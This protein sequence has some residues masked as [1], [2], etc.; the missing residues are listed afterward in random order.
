MSF[1]FGSK[2]K[3]VEQSVGNVR[4][5]DYGTNEAARPLPLF[6]GMQ[7]IGG[8]FITDLFRKRAEP[9]T[10]SYQSGKN[11][12]ATTTTGYNYYS[13]YALALALG[14][15]DELKE[16]LA[17]DD[18]IWSG[19]LLRTGA[20]SNG[21]SSVTTEL[22]VIRIYWG[23]PT[24]NVD[25]LLATLVVDEG[26]G[27]VAAP[28]SAYRHFCYVV[29]DGLFF[30]QS[31]SPPNLQFVLVRKTSGLSISAHHINNDAVLPE[32]IYDLFTNKV[33]G[34]GVP[35]SR[36]D[37]ATFEAAAQT[38]I[39]EDL[40]MSPLI[41]S[42][43]KM[44]QV[45]ADM[46]PYVNGSVYR[47]GG[48]IMFALAR[49][50]MGPVTVY[51]P[52]DLVDEPEI[53]QKTWTDTFNES[54]VSF[55]DRARSFQPNV[56][57]YNDLGNTD[58]VGGIV[59]REFPRKYITRESVAYKLAAAIGKNAGVPSSTVS[60]KLKSTVSIYPGQSFDLNYPPLGIIS[61]PYI[62]KTVK[63][64][65]PKNPVIE[66]EAEEDLSRLSAATY[67]PANDFQSTIVTAGVQNAVVRVAG[68]SS[69]QKD[70]RA[71]GLL[72]CPSR[73]NGLI[74]G[75]EIYS[76]WSLSSGWSLLSTVSTYPLIANTNRWRRY[77]ANF[78]LDLTLTH[79]H[80]QSAIQAYRDSLVELYIVTGLRRVRRTGPVDE[81]QIVASWSLIRPGGR[82]E[83]V[84]ARRWEIEVIAGRI[85]TTPFALEQF[86]TPAD[87]YYPTTTA[88]I[89]LRGDFQV[90]PSDNY[91][92]DRLGGNDPADTDQKRYVRV[93]TKTA[94]DIEELVDGATVNFDRNDST[95]NASGTYSASWGARAANAEYITLVHNDV[96]LAYWRLGEASGTVAADSTGNA[97]TGTYNGTPTLAAAGALSLDT[98]TAVT[99]NGTSH[100]VDCANP[101]AL[102]VG[103]GTVE[104]WLKTSSPGA[105]I[106]FLVGKKDAWAIVV[107]AN[108]LG[109]YNYSTSTFIG[110]GI[111]VN[112]NLWHY[113]VFTFESAL[114]NGSK[115][116]LD[117]A[118]VWT[119]MVT[120]SVQTGNVSIARSNAVSDFLAGTVDEVAIYSSK[121]TLGQVTAH[122]TAGTG[123]W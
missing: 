44:R 106:R 80:D 28:Q 13:T 22:G 98:D 45:V 42:S 43:A 1:L 2:E 4:P 92:F 86:Q 6:Y 15:V 55:N 107:N 88:Y 20:D 77:G 94:T 66:V 69:T 65:G 62:V 73:P 16:I 95:M 85:G 63:D 105:G 32:V 14:P 46:M 3:N 68:I 118:L 40:G 104:C 96:P 24:Q 117:G 18:V 79:D 120:V 123:A 10:R 12:T 72:V 91:F 34:A 50:T 109:V 39:A 37:M 90:L 23:T 64:S 5:I 121:L 111:N 82:F 81:H 53:G 17:N 57:S 58:I 30:G 38:L 122:Y 60:L 27:A 48:K 74:N 61:K 49:E 103:T 29:C 115:L 78:L 87:G 59:Q 25:G 75:G 35:A 84:A 26:A 33:Y 101:A 56:A 113:V 8:T 9:I 83:L 7:K 67:V 19:T 116:Y 31:T 89:G 21:M 70:G 112:D 54:R 99:F 102:Q 97:R 41:T 108:Q 114:S 71:D 119:G 51:G 36:I 47:Q 11:S 100:W 52:N 76:S 110:S 93:L